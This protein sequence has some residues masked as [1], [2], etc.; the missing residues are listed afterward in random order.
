MLRGT[1]PWLV[2]VALTVVDACPIL[3]ADTPGFTPLF[4]GKD[5]TGW[6]HGT[7]DL[8][9]KVETAD[10][11]FAVKDGVIRIQ[12]AKPGEPKMAEI[13]TVASL[14][15]DF[16]LKFEFR[17]SRDANSGLHL[18][19]HL[20]AH[21][22]QIRDYP[23]VGP[24]KTLKGYKDQDWNTVEVIVRGTTARCLCNGEV[25]EEA[26]TLPAKGPIGLQSEINQVE[27]RGIAVRRRP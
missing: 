27:Y 7:A 2:V 18:R 17:A 10:H 15:G 11:R 9:G 4:N 3:G 12:G 26:M 19:D 5:L 20:F 16:D 23:R 6:R 24:Y 22:L 25:L 14:D 1:I 21:Q 8:A 13:D